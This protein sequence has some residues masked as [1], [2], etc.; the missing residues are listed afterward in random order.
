VTNSAS[1]TRKEAIPVQPSADVELTAAPCHSAPTPSE[2]HPTKAPKSPTMS[3]SRAVELPIAPSSPKSP[4]RELRLKI[5]IDEL[6]SL[7]HAGN[8]NGSAEGGEGTEDEA[9]PQMLK[10]LLDGVA[11]KIRKHAKQESMRKIRTMETSTNPVAESPARSVRQ[12]VS[13]AKT[14]ESSSGSPRQRIK[15]RIDKSKTS[16]PR[17]DRTSSSLSPSKSGRRRVSLGKAD[18]KTKDFDPHSLGKNSC[19][20]EHRAARDPSQSSRRHKERSSEERSRSRSSKP[21]DSHHRDD[22][23]NPHKTP[24]PESAK[25][26]PRRSSVERGASSRRMSGGGRHDEHVRSKSSSDDKQH[27][28]SR[29]SSKTT[30]STTSSRTKAQQSDDNLGKKASLK[31][32]LDEGTDKPSR[33]SGSRSVCS[34]SSRKRREGSNSED[35]NDSSHHR[36]RKSSDSDAKASSLVKTL[37]TDEKKKIGASS[38]RSVCSRSSRKQ[39]DGADDKRLSQSYHSRSVHS[40]S[41]SV[42]SSSRSVHS[43][44]KSSSKSRKE[45]NPKVDPSTPPPKPSVSSHGSLDATEAIEYDF[46]DDPP[47]KGI[48]GDRQGRSFRR[49]SG[50]SSSTRGRSQSSRRLRS[51]NQESGLVKTGRSQSQRHIQS[52]RTSSLS[53]SRRTQSHRHLKS[54]EPEYQLGLGIDSH[55]K[56][57]SS[58]SSSQPVASSRHARPESARAESV[59]RSGARRSRSRPAP[60]DGRNELSLRSLSRSQLEEGAK[61]VASG[62]SDRTPRRSGGRGPSPNARSRTQPTSLLDQAGK[63]SAVI[64]QAPGPPGRSPVVQPQVSTTVSRLRGV[65]KALSFRDLFGRDPDPWQE[66]TSPTIQPKQSCLPV[67]STTAL[68]TTST[69]AAPAGT[70]SAKGRSMP[71]F[72]SAVGSSFQ[73]SSSS[74]FPEVSK[75]ELDASFESFHP[76]ESSGS[77]GGIPESDK[78]LASTSS[79]TNSSTTPPS[80]PFPVGPSPMPAPAPAQ[81]PPASERGWT[82][83]FFR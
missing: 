67:A 71:K 22:D 34:K 3:V 66:F 53:S 83:K 47:Q 49:G 65:H 39:R 13:S 69:T 4:H 82:Q 68:L 46:N 73:R 21:D 10:M 24:R 52:D 31:A 2:A 59:E 37:E 79:S 9:L 44:S 63:S 1:I 35:A 64:Q 6:R 23:W 76:F 8:G 51:D 16:S 81:A 55:T 14:T 20:D 11:N 32:K 57:A 61:S 48:D 43:A 29:S 72:L 26:R 18:E 50:S 70:A 54:E 78:P 33:I 38:S 74:R 77:G 36:S 41:R 15:V 27:R 58:R 19:V 7:N 56:K 60:P 12:V 80:P 17:K 75:S 28:S 5:Q 40:T 45:V 62:A 30:T 42:H 25:D